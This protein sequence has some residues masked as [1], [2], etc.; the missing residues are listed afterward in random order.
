MDPH[1]PLSRLPHLTPKGNDII[2]TPSSAA[3]A[4]RKIYRETRGNRSERGRPEVSACQRK[5]NEREEQENEILTAQRETTADSSW[6]MTVAVMDG[7]RRSIWKLGWVRTWTACK[8][9]KASLGLGWGCG[10]PNPGLSTNPRNLQHRICM[11]GGND[12]Q[13]KGKEKV[14]ELL[15]SLSLSKERSK[16][17]SRWVGCFGRISKK[18]EATA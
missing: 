14:Q 15:P 17:I 8:M 7:T 3:D 10:T 12:L 2:A 11:R 9:N 6:R 13:R 16:Y 4:R 5:F 1:P 18:G